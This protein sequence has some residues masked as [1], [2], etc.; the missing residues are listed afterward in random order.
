MLRCSPEVQAAIHAGQPVVAL[1]SSL[2]AQGLPWPINL[3]TARQAEAVVRAEGAIPATIG[4]CQGHPTVGLNDVQLEHFARAGDIRKA[5]RRDL[6]AAVG[7]G[8]WAA[9]T[10]AATVALANLAGISVLATGG[11]GGV[12]RRGHGEPPDVSA[13]LFELA[14]TPVAVVCAG[15]KSI[16]DL[17]ATLEAL[18]ALGVPVLGFGTDTFPAFYV[19]SSGLAVSDRVDTVSQ[20]AKFLRAHWHLGGAGAVLAQPVPAAEALDAESLMGALGQAEEEAV[21]SGVRGPG[22][23]PFLLRR[24]AQITQGRTLR[25]NQALVA[26]NARLAAGLARALAS[27]D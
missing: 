19:H 17:P 3:E 16:L 24:L 22:R 23:T 5:S 7:G 14:R 8:A 10:V 6:A 9:T 18:E 20:T 27:G 12:H 11:I 1:E 15:A 13:D 25:I 26:A 21:Q 2:I 4:V